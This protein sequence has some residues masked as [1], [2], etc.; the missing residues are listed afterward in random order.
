MVVV[1][2]WE[3]SINWWNNG[4]TGGWRLP[5][6]EPC[7]CVHGSLYVEVESWKRLEARLVVER[8]LQECIRS[9]QV[10]LRTDVAA[11]F[12]HSLGADE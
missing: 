2:T 6:A 9:V 5:Y 8:E 7:I 3:A 4:T 1:T 12:F 11:V 10:Q